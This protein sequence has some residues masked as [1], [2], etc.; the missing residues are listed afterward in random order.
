MFPANNE[1]KC[2]QL[3]GCVKPVAVNDRG[4]PAKF[5]S[6]AHKLRAWRIAHSEPG[7]VEVGKPEFYTEADRLQA[8]QLSLKNSSEPVSSLGLI[9]PPPSFEPRPWENH[10]V[11]RGVRA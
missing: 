5:C 2:C 6:P 9:A 8:G 11:R 7:A 4:R 10:A 3:P 1:T